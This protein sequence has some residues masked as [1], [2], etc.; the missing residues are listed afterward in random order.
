MFNSC[1][2]LTN[3]ALSGTNR[4]NIGKDVSVREN[5]SYNTKILGGCDIK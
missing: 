4:F 1:K 2:I 3:G 5:V